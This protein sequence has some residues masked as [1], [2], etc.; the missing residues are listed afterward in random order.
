MSQLFT[1]GGQNIGVSASLLPGSIWNLFSLRLIGLI[2]SLSRELPEVFSSTIV[3]RH[4]FFGALPSLSSSSHQYVTTGKTIALTR[5]TF[6]SRVR[7]L[8]FNTMSRFFIT[9]LPKSNHLISW[10]QSPSTVILEAKKRKSVTV[11][12]FLPSICQE[13]KGARCHDLR[14]LN[15]QF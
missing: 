8:F 10:L 7:S 3:R 12:T 1:S 15:I 13:V 9:F 4:Q 5:Q 11:S 6:F 14:F 2:S